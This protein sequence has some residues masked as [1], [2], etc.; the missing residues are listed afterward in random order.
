MRY[1]VEMF[2]RHYSEAG[3][4]FSAHTRANLEEKLNAMS[5]AGWLLHTVVPGES[6]WLIVFY[7]A[8]Q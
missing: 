4:G 3:E 6:G 2:S 1:H 7:R 5:E 8:D